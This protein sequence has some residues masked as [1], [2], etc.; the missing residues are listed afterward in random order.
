VYLERCVDYAATGAY[1]GCLEFYHDLAWGPAFEVGQEEI[2]T[3]HQELLK[4]SLDLIHSFKKG[5]HKATFRETLA[6]LDEYAVL[7]FKTEEGLME[8]CRYAF[9]EPHKEQ[10]RRF[11][12]LLAKLE[13]QA[14]DPGVNAV[15]LAFQVQ[16]FLTD[17]LLNHIL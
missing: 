7:H 2:D 10:H 16:V 12:A 11:V 6:F 14:A 13:R 8:G 4:R 1:Q 5:G 3:Q 17:W 15:F 9:L